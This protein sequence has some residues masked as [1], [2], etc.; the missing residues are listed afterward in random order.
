MFA[1]EFL[2]AVRK[3]LQRMPRDVREL[4]LA[5]VE[6]LA[7]DPFHAPNVRKLEGR[8]GWRLREW[9]IIYTLEMN[10]LTV[11]VVKIGTRGKVYQ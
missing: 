4:I 1:I 7:Q 10:R 8:E 11:V 2:P 3:S 6:T 5:K 9:R